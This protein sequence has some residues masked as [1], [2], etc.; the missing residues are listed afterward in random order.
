[1]SGIIIKNRPE[2]EDLREWL[3]KCDLTIVVTPTKLGWHATFKE[4]HIVEGGFA[5]PSGTSAVAEAESFIRWLSGCRLQC[6]TNAFF[7]V[8]EF[9]GVQE[10]LAAATTQ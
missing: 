1:M 9:T 2:T 5:R 10:A 3:K 4:P 8:P 7:I 6:G